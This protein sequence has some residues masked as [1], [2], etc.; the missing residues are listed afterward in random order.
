MMYLFRKNGPR[1]PP[2]AFR[3]LS[4]T[5]LPF[6]RVRAN[7]IEYSV[8]NAEWDGIIPNETRTR[9]KRID[10]ASPLCYLV[11]LAG[12]NVIGA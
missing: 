8:T 1:P 5:S 7:G 11:Y 3:E 10:N 4:L 12:Y 6:A 2:I 9:C